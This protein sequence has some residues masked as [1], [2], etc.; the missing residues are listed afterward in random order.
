MGIP[1][2]SSLVMAAFLLAGSPA[3]A[4]AQPDSLQQTAPDN[5]KTNKRD[6]SQ[7]QPTADQQKEN[8]VDREITRKIRSAI[9][10]D[11]ALSTDAHNIKIIT[12]N[13]EVTLKGPVR[14]QDEKDSA[15]AKAV[16]VVG[17]GHVTNQLEVATK[18]E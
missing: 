8:S 12:Q 6:R 10:R 5:T 17:Q 18:K 16:S 2:L 7:N 13:G 4:I 1:L 11:K 15:E 9:M 14:T 3:R